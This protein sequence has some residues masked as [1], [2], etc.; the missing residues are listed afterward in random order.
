MAQ[1][2][3]KPFECC[4]R[5]AFVEIYVPCHESCVLPN[6]K[7]FICRYAASICIDGE[8]LRGL[9]EGFGAM[10]LKQKIVVVFLVALMV[11]PLYAGIVDVVN[12]L[13]GHD[14]IESLE[15][16]SDRKLNVTNVF[17]IGDTLIVAATSGLAD[18]YELEVYCN[19]SSVFVQS[20]AFN[21][22]SA[23]I[24]VPLNPPEFLAGSSYLVVFVAYAY[25]YPIPGA[26]TSD[27]IDS[28]YMIIAVDTEIDL[29]V[30]YDSSIGSLSLNASLATVDGFPIPDEQIGFALQ[31]N[32]HRRNEGWIP[33]TSMKTKS[34]GSARTN[35]AFGLP[36][37]NYY[38]KAF[39]KAN[40]NFGGSENKTEIGIF[41]NVAF[42][43]L[44][45]G[46]S[47]AFSISSFGN[48]TLSVSSPSPYVL[49]PTNAT[50][51]Y[52]SDTP[53]PGP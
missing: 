21:E 8:L 48:L 10:N 53:L 7:Y 43:G 31:F 35:L 22:G 39:H 36:D 25:D 41:S 32:K 4:Q 6:H 34:D 3:E 9:V 15:L 45:S 26:W 28:S 13:Q 1:Q 49:L 19:S 52:V 24:P 23:Q 42:R 47:S 30:G 12:A 20:G 18:R 14:L 16:R 27:T 50:A 29:W 33:L 44:D 37:G 17:D 2:H 46:S 5:L 40:G 11:L 51:S 38:I